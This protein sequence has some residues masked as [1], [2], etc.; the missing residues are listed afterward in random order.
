VFGPGHQ[1]HLVAGL[2]QFS[3]SHAEDAVG[4]NIVR[5]G[6][7]FRERAN[8]IDYLS[9]RGVD[10][11]KVDLDEAAARSSVMTQTHKI[12]LEIPA[13]SASACRRASRR[14]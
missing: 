13:D 8:L 6:D 11:V 4:Q 12:I 3:I 7:A 5:G 1:S 10:I 9:A 2:V 14:R